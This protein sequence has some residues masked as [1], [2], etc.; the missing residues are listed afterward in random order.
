GAKGVHYAGKAFLC[1][2]IVRWLHEEGLSL[3][4]CTAGELGL[5]LRAGFPAGRIA[6]HGSNKSIGELTTAVRAE[7]GAIVIDSFDE[8]ARLAGLAEHRPAAEAIPVMVRITVG[9][10]AHTHEFIATA[11]EDQKFGFSLAGGDA[12]EAVRRV[13]AIPGLRLIGLH[14]H[15]GSQILRPSGFEVAAHRVV[16]LLRQIVAAHPALADSIVAL[17]LGGGLGIAYTSAHDPPAP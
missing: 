9:G 1:T 11:H 3:D 6:L 13:V 10:E 16:A 17:D 12:A 14:S 5:A 15:I 4:V 8:I 2:E 7:I